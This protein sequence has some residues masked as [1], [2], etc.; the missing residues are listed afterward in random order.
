MTS[1]P[2][3]SSG[4]VQYND[5]GSFGGLTGSLVSGSDLTLGGVLA[6]NPSAGTQAFLETHD[7]TQIWAAAPLFTTGVA[8]FDGVNSGAGSSD[9]NVVITWGWNFQNGG[10]RIDTGKPAWGFSLEYNY[11]LN[12]SRGWVQ[13]VEGHWKMQDTT[14]GTEHRPITMWLPWDGGSGSHLS[15]NSDALHFGKFDPTASDTLRMTMDFS[16]ANF[17]LIYFAVQTQMEVGSNNTAFIRQKNAAGTDNVSYPYIDNFDR[18]ACV[19]P[20]VIAPQ[21]P[22]SSLHS[23]LSLFGT[24]MTNGSY[25]ARFSFPN[26]VTGSVNAVYVAGQATGELVDTRANYGS[27]HV[28]SFVQSWTGNAIVRFGRNGGLT[29]ACGLDGADGDKWKLSKSSNVGTSDCL[30]IDTSGN[31]KVGGPLVTIGYTVAGL[32]PAST[33]LKGARA[34]VTDAAGPT[35]LGALTGG[36]SV[37]SPVFC[38]GT[39]WVAG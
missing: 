39:A 26:S 29:W 5:S 37:V 2:G 33:A 38:N 17:S 1:V 16:I 7:V 14:S 3:G 10:G 11:Y 34:H 22:D 23:C 24:T 12:T 31:V 20:T 32:P 25:L 19:A 30:I 6:V 27:G 18:I 21:Q 28:V 4:Q 36:G 35:F 13:G 8:R 9:P 15:F